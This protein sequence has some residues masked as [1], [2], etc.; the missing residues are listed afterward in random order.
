VGPDIEQLFMTCIPRSLPEEIRIQRLWTCLGAIWWHWC[1]P[2]TIER[3]FRAICDQWIQPTNDLWGLLSKETWIAAAR[4]TTD[5]NPLTAIRAH[6]IQAL[7]AVMWRK[8]K[9]ACLPA[10]A[11]SLLQNQLGAS[12]VD[13]DKWYENEDHLQLVV[14]ANLLSNVLPLL[15]KLETANGPDVSFKNEI[16]AILNMICDELVASDIPDE[17]RARFANGHEV[18][19]VFGVQ[20]H[21]RRRPAIDTQGSWTKIFTP[22][23]IGRGN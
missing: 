10:E 14:A 11:S 23:E 17:L 19:E 5:S 7:V 2:S 13:I 21:F 15:R 9:W 16:K 22:I 20:R 3:H 6:C 12:S 1:F 8:G 18:M 4:M